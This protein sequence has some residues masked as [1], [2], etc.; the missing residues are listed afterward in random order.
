MP[1]KKAAHTKKAPVKAY[2][3][4]EHDGKKSGGTVKVK[5]VVTSSAAPMICGKPSG[6]SAC[7]ECIRWWSAKTRRRRVA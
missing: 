2:N 7:G 5:W 3:R 6:A 4:T 1:G